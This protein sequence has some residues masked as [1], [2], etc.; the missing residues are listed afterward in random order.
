MAT[1][2]RVNAANELIVTIEAALPRFR[3]DEGES[4]WV[5]RIA[6]FDPDVGGMRTRLTQAL[7]R[8]TRFDLIIVYPLVDGFPL[9]A[10]MSTARVLGERLAAGGWLLLAS[11]DQ[12]S[13]GELLAIAAASGLTILC[14]LPGP[15]RL[16]ALIRR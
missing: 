1:I 12:F 7:E 15:C 5:A 13:D 10:M 9:A 8:P 16:L 14:A 2:G 4:I 11:G 3:P 6:S